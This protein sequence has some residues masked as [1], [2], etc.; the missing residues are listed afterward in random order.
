MIIRN[1]FCSEVCASSPHQF[2][3]CST[4]VSFHKT[5]A[6]HRVTKTLGLEGTSGGHLLHPPARAGPPPAA[7]DRVLMALRFPRVETHS[8]TGWSVLVLCHPHSEKV[9][10]AAQ[11]ESPVFQC[12]PITSGCVAGHQWTEPG[13]V[14][15]A[16]CLQG[17]AKPKLIRSPWAFFTPS[18]TAPALSASRRGRDGQVSPS[19]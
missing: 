3:R 9:L 17:G 10:P 2:P 13:S 8:L 15:F 12:V 4:S 11:R 1:E 16:L 5:A 14:L 7:Q 6:L 19:L 18:W